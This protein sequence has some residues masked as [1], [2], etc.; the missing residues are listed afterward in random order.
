MDLTLKTSHV[1]WA[2][3]EDDNKWIIR[4]AERNKLGSFPNTWKERDCAAALDVG[5]KFEKI[6]YEQ[7]LEEGKEISKKIF[8][9]LLLDYYEQVQALKAMNE[10]LSVKLEQLIIGE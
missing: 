6:A 8:E 4:D 1:T 10:K 3:A 9:P 2:L 5:I 7:G